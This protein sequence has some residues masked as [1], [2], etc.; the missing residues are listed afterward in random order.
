MNGKWSG[1]SGISCVPPQRLL[2]YVVLIIL[3][4]LWQPAAGQC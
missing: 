1:I 3:A 2:S 4:L